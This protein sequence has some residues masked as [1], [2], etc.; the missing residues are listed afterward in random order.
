MSFIAQKNLKQRLKKIALALLGLY[1]MV[2]TTL[3]LLQEKFLFLPEVLPQEYEYNLTYNYDEYFLDTPNSGVIN[4]LH[5][6]AN[7]PKGAILYFHGN[8]GNLKRW[9]E[10]AEY[11]VAMNYDVYIMDYRTYGKSKG[12]LSE[13]ALYK[14]AQEC[15]NHL[16]QFWNEHDIVVYGRSLGSAMATKI[17]STNNPKKLYHYTHHSLFHINLR[18]PIPTPSMAKTL[19]NPC[20][21]SLSEAHISILRGFIKKVPHTNLWVIVLNYNPPFFF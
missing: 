6:K 11:F 19:F 20:F 2:G 12:V 8:A 4:T 7:N 1:I 9:S 21:K 5:I 14:D 15:Y 10:V 3:Y 17:A 13:V 18:H 16:K